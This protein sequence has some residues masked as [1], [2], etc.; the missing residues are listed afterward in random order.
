MLI[1]KSLLQL[2][3]LFI[4]FTNSALLAQNWGNY[5]LIATQN[6]T[7]VKLI[8]HNGST[9]KSW[10]LSGQT[11]YSSYLLPN[12][13]LIR[14]VKTTGA[15]FSG[16]GI[17]GR[18][19]KVDWNGTILW[20]Y[21]YSASNY[22]THHDFEVLPNGNVLAI[23]YEKKTGA[24]LTAVGYTGTQTT[25]WSEAIIE[26]QPNGTNG[27]NIVWE[28]HLWDH[29]VQNVNAS[30][31]N[32]G[33]PS[34]KPELLNINYN[35]NRT[36]WVHANGIDYNPNTNQIVF[37]S[38]FLNEVYII[39]HSTTTAQAASHSG[40]N[41]GKGGDFLYRWGNP[42]AYGGSGV[43]FNVIHDAHWVP[44]GVPNAGDIVVFHNN[45]GSGQSSVDRFTPNYTLSGGTYLP[46][47]LSNK[48][49]C[50][51][52]SSNMGNSQ[53]LPN[54]NSLYC[55]AT[56]G[57]IGEANS[58]NT[59][60]WTYNAGGTTPQ[61]SRYDFCFVNGNPTGTASAASTSVC[62][63][64]STTLSITPDITASYT[65]TWSSTN[66]FS[67]TIQNPS[68][69]PTS[70]GTYTVIMDAGNG[71]T[72]TA[73]VT[74]NV[75]SPPTANAGT[76]VTISQGQSTT[77]TASGGTT[78]S[79]S[80][81]QNST[82]IN[83]SPT[84]TT[85]YTVTVTGSGGCTATDQVIVNV[86][87]APVSVVASATQSTVCSGFTTQINATPSG[88]TGTNTF[89]WSSNP[90]GFSST[91]Q[92]P[93]VSPTVTTTYTVT[94][95][96]GANTSTSS[97][98][99]NVNALPSANAGADVT[100][101]QGQST[102]LTASGGTTYN[103][104]N[105][106]NGASITVN[107]TATTTYY[108]TV[109]DVNGCKAIANVVVTVNLPAVTASASTSN[110]F[111]CFGSSTQ[112]NVTATGGNNSYTY[113]W[114]SDPSGFSSNSLNPIV[115]PTV[116]TTYT[117]TVTSVNGNSTSSVTILV[118]PLP[119]ANA[120]SDVAITFGQSA[121][122]TASGGVS[123][124]WSNGANTQNTAVTPSTTT[125][126]L[127]TV[128]D[129]NGCKAIDDIIVT[130]NYPSVVATASANN[131]NV[132][133]NTIVQLDV[134]A[135]GGNNS[136][137]Y[138][139][140]ANNGGFSSSQKNPSV[141]LS[142]TTTYTVTV[143][144]AGN[145]TISSVTINVFSLPL[146][147]AGVDVN[148]QNG[149]STTLTASGGVLYQWSNGQNTQSVSVSPSSTTTYVVTVTDSNG[150]KASDEVV[151]FVSY[152][153]LAASA[154]ASQTTICVGTSVQLDVNASGG[155]N[156][157]TY[158]W[159]TSNGGVFS[160]QKNPTVFPTT[161]T[162]Y[163]VTVTSI[164]GS[165][166]SSIN[167]IVNALPNANAGA[168]VSIIK[169]NSTT[170]TATGGTTYFWS[171][172][173][174]TAS[175]SVSPLNTTTYT[176]TVT[177]A[178][179]CKASDQV[180]VTVNLPA[181]VVSSTIS[182]STICSGD[183]SQ[184]E[185]SATG[186]IGTYTY[187]WASN[188]S[189]FSSTDKIIKV[190]PIVTTNY[191]V[192][193][194]SGISTS[195]LNHT[196]TVN[197]TPVANAG[198]DVSVQIG[199]SVTLTASGGGSYLWSNGAT[200]TSIDVKPLLTTTYIVTVTN[201]F[202]CSSSD[203]VEVSVKGIPLSVATSATE[204]VI[205]AGKTIQL[206]AQASGGTGSNSYIWSSNQGNLNSNIQSPL[207]NPTVTT[208][209][210]VT[211]TNGGV[212][213][214]S[215]ITITVNPNPIAYAGEDITIS[216]GQT[217]ILT[218]SGGE[219]YNWSTKD[220][221]ATI[222]V[223]PT[224]TTVYFVTA[225]NSTGCFGIDQVYVYVVPQLTATISSQF[226]EICE[227][228]SVQLNVTT[229]GGFG[230]KTY[231][232]AS[233]PTSLSS[234]L[235]NPVVSP[236]VTSVYFVTITDAVGSTTVAVYTLKVNPTPAAAA[237]S[238]NKD[239][240]NASVTAPTYQWYLNGNAIQNAT[241]QQYVPSQNGTYQVD[242]IDLASCKSKISAEYKYTK[243]GIVD[244]QNSEILSLFPN[245]FDNIIHI[246]GTILLN[247]FKIELL[248]LQGQVLKQIKGENQINLDFLP[249]GAYLIKIIQKESV[250][251]RKVSKI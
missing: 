48:I 44:D 113:Q 189:G 167:I 21:T 146:A 219:K 168:D 198:A 204:T 227:G 120:G 130:V 1:N 157:F 37:S 201:S 171:T 25:L 67:S 115:S 88:G 71:C 4:C 250:F 87:A 95:T 184:I 228:V 57:T 191:T 230:A 215:S 217:A 209:Y 224:E 111:I 28:W 38:H 89:N 218:A 69:S 125:T 143:T 182:K 105:G 199:N 226:A 207:V 137:T 176:V 91:S 49:I 220:S 223:N 93:F 99:I 55:V 112:L 94:V 240:L 123:Y 150:C 151:V 211:V 235:Q 118:K 3:L 50:N 163:T 8:N 181:L 196:I 231:Q 106:Q 24:D 164:N 33:V 77:L 129:A 107:P 73:S 237:I 108:V 138:T 172:G 10:S 170:L 42:A 75:L 51:G 210:T 197:P 205:C 147:N 183:S 96:N 56:Q 154:S 117:V 136:F 40:G 216:A 194:T 187:K 97:V 64:K 133:P 68:I 122:L 23:V 32:Y 148:I 158:T 11:G 110:P 82:S 39:D 203:Q 249:S 62:P 78:Y 54:G 155:N 31:S 92:N 52:F 177:S 180:V 76:D 190:K 239:T 46:T 225:T 2:S 213:A 134:N 90:S 160:S 248:N 141:S 20:D 66:G 243:I 206:K 35:S 119:N 185:V 60:F 128:T 22:I 186:S 246:K 84:I 139:W 238:Q 34:Q 30:L 81:G 63:G 103:W 18:L 41:S 98:T 101:T 173:E 86:S 179:G 241:K 229:T 242:Y 104:N 200:T 126:Y 195:I 43:T 27:A 245:P 74:V 14:A 162:I 156:S 80:N 109:T 188:P 234:T 26:F 114:G 140:G 247:D 7:T 6:S 202:G 208:I 72:G 116:T 127:V 17:C 36:D 100:I 65:Y 222:K 9:Y 29:L 153:P 212:T 5:T 59:T 79:W 16:G 142:Q 145:S 236:T 121:T 144:S 192:T 45:G 83:V 214:T 19:Q 135:S 12:R 169:G 161:N 165:T 149:Q 15:S 131:T 47:A 61:A 13:Q 159:G 152:P 178:A 251:I 174:S 232:W 132:C 175:I 244:T 58:S 221:V 102:T 193:V 124:V 166:I 70:S 53:Q 85:T 233:N